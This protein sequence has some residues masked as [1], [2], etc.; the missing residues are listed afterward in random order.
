MAANLSDEILFHHVFMRLP[1]KSLLRCKSV[2]KAWNRILCDP[3]FIRMHFNRQHLHKLLIRIPGNKYYSV[4]CEEAI[5]SN[6]ADAVKL[7]FPPDAYSPTPQLLGSYNGLVCIAIDHDSFDLGKKLLL[8]NP[9]TRESNFVPDP[10]PYIRFYHLLGF[11]YDSTLDDYKIV[12]IIHTRQT[13]RVDMYSLKNNSWKIVKDVPPNGCE[14][15]LCSDTHPHGFEANGFI[16][17]LVYARSKVLSNCLIVGFCLRDD[18]FTVLPLPHDCGQFV[19]D[20]D[21]RALGGCLAA[22]QSHYGDEFVV[23]TTKEPGKIK[24]DRL[25]THSISSPDYEFT[26]SVKPVCFMKN[27]K[28]LLTFRRG[29]ASRSSDVRDV[30]SPNPSYVN[31]VDNSMPARGLLP[32]LEIHLLL[33][34]F[35][36]DTHE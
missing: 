15:K 20:M 36:G 26:W 18:K 4:D 33:I 23:W 27:G 7:N 1:I 29:D 24:W 8:W 10:N 12:R 25:I 19:S 32:V 35:T 17:W 13:C 6:G 22:F 9:S 2:C 11:A 3:E 16:Y 30:L 21:L 28:V 34:P 5:S 14:F 31:K